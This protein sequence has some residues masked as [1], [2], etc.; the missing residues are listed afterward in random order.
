MERN[1]IRIV[2]IHF[3]LISYARQVSFPVLLIQEL[4]FN[5][6]FL[7]AIIEIYITFFSKIVLPFFF[8]RRLLPVMEYFV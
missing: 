5:T 1:L 4:A 6:S 8:N 7:F 3:N 2:I